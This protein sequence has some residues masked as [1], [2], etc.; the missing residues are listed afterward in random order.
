MKQLAMIQL[1][2]G[3]IYN[4]W[5]DTAFL[6]HILFTR[7]INKLSIVKKHS[8]I[9]C[10][11]NFVTRKCETIFFNDTKNQD[12]NDLLLKKRFFLAPFSCL[13]CCYTQ[14]LLSQ[15]HSKLI[16]VLTYRCPLINTDSTHCK[17]LSVI[18]HNLLSLAQHTIKHLTLY[19]IS[20]KK[21]IDTVCFD[22]LLNLWGSYF[23]GEK[24]KKPSVLL[25]LTAIDDVDKNTT[26]SLSRF[27]CLSHADKHAN[28]KFL[29]IIIH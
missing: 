21:I 10:C 18:Q 28:Y 20:Y 8:F 27:Q 2:V 16:E 26:I 6:K 25:A 17:S 4:E 11:V 9:I 15:Y 23:Y 22:A 5:S 29:Q 12:F 13:Q 14:F 7:A 19:F 24:V 1:F 3:K